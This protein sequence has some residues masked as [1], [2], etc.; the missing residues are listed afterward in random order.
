[1]VLDTVVLLAVLVEVLAAT[2]ELEEL[3]ESSPIY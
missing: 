1:V 3:D 2:L